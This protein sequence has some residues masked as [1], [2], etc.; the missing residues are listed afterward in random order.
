[1]VHDLL[2]VLEAIAGDPGNRNSPLFQG[3]EPYP[4]GWRASRP[5]PSTLPHFPMVLHRGGFPDGS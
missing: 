5:N 1:M 3:L 4:E 2:R